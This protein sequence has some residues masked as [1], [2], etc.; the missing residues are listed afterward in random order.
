MTDLPLAVV[1]CGRIA[2]RM[3]LKVLRDLPGVRV[4]ALA[5]PD[6]AQ[7]DAASRIVPGAARYGDYD[8]LF[9][10]SDAA[11]VVVCAPPAL[12]A[13]AAAAAFGAG[14]HVYVEKPV[15]TSLAD[16]EAVLR[17]QRAAGTVGMVGFNYRFQ[18]LYRALRDALG[19]VGTP[20]AVRTTFC[21]ARRELPPWKRDRETGGGA[22]LDLASHHVDLVRFLFGREVAEARARTRSVHT[23]D[24]TVALE[25]V[26]DDGLVVQSLFTISGVEQDHVEVVGDAGGLVAD[27]FDPGAGVRFVP[28]K[29]SYGRA[30]RVREAAVLAGGA[31]RRL[32][33]TLLPEPE[34]S[35]GAALRRFVQAVAT[36]RAPGATLEDGYRSLAV[37]VAAEASVGSGRAEAPAALPDLPAPPDADGSAGGAGTGGADRPALS[38]VLVATDR[39]ADVRRTARHLQAQTV[40]DR[41]ELVVVGPEPGSLGDA[42]PDELEGFWGVQTVYAGGPIDN[43]DKAAAP[44]IRAASAPLVGLVEDHAFPEPGWAEAVVA[45]FDAPDGPWAAVGSTVE[46]ANPDSPLSWTNQLL[47]YGTWTEPVHRGPTGHVSR[48]NITFRKAVLDEYGDRLVDFLGRDGGLLLDLGR[49]GHRFFLEPAARVRHAN[50]SLLASTV[51]LR[52]KGGRVYAATR[53]RMGG[54]SAAKRA[55]Y[56]AGSPA[57]P[58][59]RYR[60]LHPK[61]PTAG[62]RVL[63]ALALG[64]VLDAAGQAVGFAAGAGGA[65]DDL[66]AFEFDRNRHMTPGDRR[67][68]SA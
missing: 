57:F 51:G 59:L 13:P 44:G 28:T 22:A 37:V 34:P 12:H 48:H 3:H 35:F 38:V 65:A 64:L 16:A 4:V 25:L 29:R 46:N 43:V 27:R 36:G 33:H 54:W 40:R 6:P 56:V 52:F 2:Q 20:V 47:A 1:G 18:P 41:V 53:A 24:D 8:E 62:W 60:K 42:R 15:A 11:A 19:R 58:V 61:L 68:L 5:D 30:D 66:A 14:R 50:P 45:A 26:L 49:R 67:L 31:G 63:P 17:A 21:T 9:A 23:G 55:V 7:L 10:A 39:F 32:R